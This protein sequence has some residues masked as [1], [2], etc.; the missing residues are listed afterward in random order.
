[1]KSALN[2]K[3]KSTVV[4]TA[5]CCLVKCNID[6]PVMAGMMEILATLLTSL[7]KTSCR[8]YKK[9]TTHFKNALNQVCKH[10]KGGT[11][12]LADQS[13]ETS[14]RCRSWA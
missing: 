8:I 2:Y 4:Q 6:K 5:T 10:H 14:G 7:F 3:S 11:V 13:P 1:M 12:F 9:Q